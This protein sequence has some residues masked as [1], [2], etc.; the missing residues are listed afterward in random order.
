MS[1][2]LVTQAPKQEAAGPLKSFRAAG[3]ERVNQSSS[4]DS[5]FQMQRTIG[6][7]AMLGL[8][9]S[10]VLQAKLRISQPGDADEVEADRI[11]DQI[12]STSHL[13]R[14]QRKCSC[15]GS[16]ACSKCSEEDDVIHRSAAS[17]FILRKAGDGDSGNNHDALAVKT[18]LGV[19]HALDSRVEG[20]MSSAFDYDFSGVLVHTDARAAML[21]SDLQA[22]AFTIGSDIAFASGEYQ[23][24]TP[25]GDALIAHELAHVVQQGGGQYVTAPMQKGPAETGELEEDADL[26]AVG[27][28]VSQRTGVRGGL[29]EIGRDAS[30][31]LRSGLRLQRCG[32]ATPAVKPPVAPTQT[33]RAPEPQAPTA[34]QAPQPHQPT[35]AE[36]IPRRYSRSFTANKLS[37]GNV[38]RAIRLFGATNVANALVAWLKQHKIQATAVFIASSDEM[39]G[40]ERTADGTFEQV[41]ARTY[42]VYVLAAS[43]SSQFVPVGDRG[44]KQLKQTLVDADPK[45]MADTLFHELLHV[46]FVN[47][48]ADADYGYETGHTSQVKPTKIVGES[49]TYDDPQYDERFLTKLNQFD[50]QLREV[51][52]KEQEQS[53]APVLQRKPSSGNAGCGNGCKEDGQES[54]LRATRIK[55]SS[56]PVIQRTSANKTTPTSSPSVRG[57]DRPS[58]LIVEDDAAAVSPGQ[59][60]KSD[61]IEQ[62]RGALCATTDAALVEAGQTTKGC[63]YI[64]KWLS[65]YSTTSSQ[66]LEGA[67]IKYA[68]EAARSRTAKEYIPIVCNRVHRAA[69]TWAKTGKITGI[70]DDLASQFA[71]QGLLGGIGGFFSGVAGSVLG[72]FGGTSKS[73]DS[74]SSGIFRKAR[75]EGS[76]NTGD[77]SR[78]KAQL[79]VG[80]Y[81][82]SR[83]QAQMSSAYGY[84][85]SGVR[86]HTDSRAAEISSNL[87]ARAFTIGNDIAFASGEYQPATPV[88]DALIAHELAHVVQQD[89]GKH[90][91]A[92]LKKGAHETHQL[93]EDADLSALGAVTSIWAGARI[94]VTDIGKNALPRL[95]SGL[96]LQRCTKQ[97]AVKAPVSPA[98]QLVDPTGDWGTRVKEA[99]D[100]NDV[101]LMRALVQRAL[102]QQADVRTPSKESKTIKAE[103][104]SPMPVINFDVNLNSKKGAGTSTNVAVD[105]GY[106]FQHGSK[107][108]I[109]LGPTALDAASPLITKMVKEHEEYHVQHHM[110]DKD[111]ASSSK[112]SEQELET[113]TVDF[114]HYFHQFVHIPYEQ[115][116]TWF[117]LMKYYEESD[118]GPRKAALD[119]LAAYYAAIPVEAAELPKYQKAV[120]N[121]IHRSLKRSDL[122]QKQLLIDLEQKLKG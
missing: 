34:V 8:F 74:K 26:S 110:V 92:P 6:N 96:K 27:A 78:V 109:I 104:Y 63:P 77:A 12:V 22:R 107:A 4:G 87:D 101:P 11:A 93:E 75:E 117:P 3:P 40:K 54:I 30:P 70:P 17:P 71:G 80:H 100:K 115:R 23:P 95:R 81:L 20:Q 9:E 98:T 57:V 39:P 58:Q 29:T 66:H 119:K 112:S 89:G 79:G 120:I 91:E 21:S 36:Q 65:H 72:F 88:G 37:P 121:W 59:M 86:V 47:A 35:A 106:F 84:D 122:S 2:R 19:G 111:A 42:N 113:W 5:L 1:N 56:E 28:V 43:V 85:F 14:L 99:K 33:V 18:E 16:S 73:E 46:W 32:G 82:D 53:P 68:P 69:T 97:A 64:E 114:T 67:L 15:A 108:Y 10:G 51:R 105:R 83:V 50:A 52:K 94:G 61:F 45:S 62:L 116:P 44:V 90:P 25:I 24:G 76:A 48:G 60:R 103:D 13:P 7:Q 102:G 41:G 31:R 118:Q 55:R 38:D 49:K